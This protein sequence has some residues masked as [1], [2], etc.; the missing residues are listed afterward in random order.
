MGLPPNRMGCV[1]TQIFVSQTVSFNDQFLK[2]LDHHI[3]T[4]KQ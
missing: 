3:H 1:A 4:L 2:V